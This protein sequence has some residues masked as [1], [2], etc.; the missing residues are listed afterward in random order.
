MNDSRII[1]FCCT[2][3]KFVSEGEVEV[4]GAHYNSARLLKV[5]EEFFDVGHKLVSKCDVLCMCH[6]CKFSL[7]EPAKEL[8]EEPFL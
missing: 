1:C 4:Q 7:R 2:L 6:P 8:V 3:H 5:L